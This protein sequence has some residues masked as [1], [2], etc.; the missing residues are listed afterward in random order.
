[1]YPYRVYLTSN[2]Y[3]FA[4]EKEKDFY[5]VGSDGNNLERLRLLIKDSKGVS[6]ELRSSGLARIVRTDEIDLIPIIRAHNELQPIG[7]LLVP[8]NPNR[9][10][11]RLVSGLVL[12]RIEAAGEVSDER[13]DLVGVLAYGFDLDLD[14]LLFVPFLR[15]LALFRGVQ[16]FFWFHEGF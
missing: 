3:L 15:S 11:W 7:P 6:T 5:L 2:P 10:T 13:R 4:D 8:E 9:G 1:M 16:F 14:F 12:E